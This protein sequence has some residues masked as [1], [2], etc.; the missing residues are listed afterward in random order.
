MRHLYLC[1]FLATTCI[2]EPVLAEPAAHQS[3]E[4]IEQALRAW[5][6]SAP[7]A[8]GKAPLDD[9]ARAIS[10]VCTNPAECMYLAAL[11][12]EESRFVDWVVDQRCNDETWRQAHQSQRACDSGRA[13]GP[14][15]VQDERFRGTSPDFQAS[16]VLTMFRD[17]PGRWATWKKASAVAN[18]WLRAHPWTP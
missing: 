4:R 13:F 2:P 7:G 1:C 8:S 16:V 15:Q 5:N 17:Y 6:P 10:G 14:W 12:S 3:A 11:A 18:A 9:W